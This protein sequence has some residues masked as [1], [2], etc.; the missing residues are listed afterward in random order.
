MGRDAFADQ[1]LVQGMLSVGDVSIGVVEVGDHGEVE[2]PFDAAG[3]VP[4]FV[5]SDSSD[6]VGKVGEA[7]AS[8][9]RLKAFRFKYTG[10]RCLGCWDPMG[11]AKPP[12]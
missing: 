6:G 4:V 3:V 8:L 1:G 12:S 2:V 9:L 10:V 5:T 11:P 7:V